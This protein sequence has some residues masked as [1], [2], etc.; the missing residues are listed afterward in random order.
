MAQSQGVTATPTYETQIIRQF[1]DKAKQRIADHPG[2]MPFKPVE[3]NLIIGWLI[4]LT[5][6]SEELK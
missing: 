6:R 5:E 4:A 3:G 1:L 2:K